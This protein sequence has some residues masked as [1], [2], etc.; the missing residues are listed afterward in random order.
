M[1]QRLTGVPSVCDER[2]PNHQMLRYCALTFK[3]R[4]SSLRL[5]RNGKAGGGRREELRIESSLDWV[6]VGQVIVPKD[7][8]LPWLSLRPGS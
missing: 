7:M 8:N 1:H 2:P 5:S 3:C 6:M 4:C